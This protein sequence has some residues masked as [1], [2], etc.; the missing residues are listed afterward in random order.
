MVYVLQG[1]KTSGV[2]KK[3][4]THWSYL[5]YI[6]KITYI[7]SVFYKVTFNFRESRF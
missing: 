3:K 2:K 4:T 6:T 1:N 7:G 5:F